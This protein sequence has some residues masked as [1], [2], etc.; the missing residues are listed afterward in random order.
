MAIERDSMV[1]YASWLDAVRALPK[2]MQGDV[3]LTILEYGIEGKTVCAQGSV[4]TAMLA[5]VKPTID[6][7]N[8]RYENSQKGGRPK[9]NENQTETKQKPNEN[10]TETKPKP[11]EGKS[12]PNNVY[13][14]DSIIT[15]SIIGDN[16]HTRE[17]ESLDGTTVAVT[18]LA[19]VML[20]DAKWVSRV[21]RNLQKTEDDICTLVREFCKEQEIAGDNSREI[22]EARKHFINWQRK[23]LNQNENKRGLGYYGRA[24]NRGVSAAELD[25]AIAA[26]IAI[27]STRQEWEL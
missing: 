25:E 17:D 13:V 7:N 26:G 9:S 24:G 21:A 5:M 23:K 20:S 27:G 4:A 15:T 18:S 11:S 1:F 16:A 22:G 8:K 3:L 10:Q 19:K 14:Y 12:K 6:T 2:A